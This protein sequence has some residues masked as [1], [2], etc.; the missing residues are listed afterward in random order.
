MNGGASV[1]A[2]NSVIS[3]I[4]VISRVSAASVV[5]ISSTTS[6]K[7]SSCSVSDSPDGSIASTSS[8]KISLS[9]NSAPRT[10]LPL[11]I[12]SE[13]DM[14]R[15]A[16]VIFQFL[17]ILFFIKTYSFL[18]CFTVVSAQEYVHTVIGISPSVLFTDLIKNGMFSSN[19]DKKKVTLRWN[20][21]K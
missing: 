14:I 8:K 12:R 6:A 21:A 10:A 17:H 11:P 3:G 16:P 4:S 2:G 1:A 9:A 18:L 13:Q 7:S 19:D 15:A 5:L 20:P